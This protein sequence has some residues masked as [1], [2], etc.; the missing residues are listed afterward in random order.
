VFSFQL[1]ESEKWLEKGT[2][3]GQV[4]NHHDIK[5]NDLVYNHL[6]GSIQ[7]QWNS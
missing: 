4:G 5:I 3:F 6:D 2:W 7:G 1:V